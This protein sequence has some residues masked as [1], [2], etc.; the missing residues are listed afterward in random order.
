MKANKDKY[1]LLVSGRCY[2]T[3][4][5]CG[6]EIKL[7]KINQLHERYLRVIYKDKT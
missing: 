4:N 2:E 6:A 1:Y 7:V 5:V 3:V